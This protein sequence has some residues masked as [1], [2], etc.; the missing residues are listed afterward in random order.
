VST[1]RLDPVLLSEHEHDG[2]WTL[3]L[4]VPDD[5]A[6][7]PGHF[8]QAPVL[9]GVVQVAWAL[10]FAAQRFGTPARC[11]VMEALK[12]QR[13]LRPGDRVALTLRHD[14]ARH[15]VH[16]AYRAGDT[17]CSSGRLAWSAEP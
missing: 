1:Q 15:K 13:L 2:V 4:Q 17:A 14:V 9:P 6:Y 8:P 12:F 16:F 7:F 10:T 11:R 5:L 3:T